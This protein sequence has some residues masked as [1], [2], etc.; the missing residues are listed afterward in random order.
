M[1]KILH[2]PASTATF[3][4]EWEL[5]FFNKVRVAPSCF[6]I[7]SVDI[8]VFYLRYADMSILYS[9]SKKYIGIKQ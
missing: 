6:I 7:K 9:Q 4:R 8:D 1:A 5:S 3:Y 2:L